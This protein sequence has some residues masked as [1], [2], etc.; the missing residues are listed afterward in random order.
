MVRKEK[1]R[2]DR[3]ET[4]KKR[5]GEGKT[6]HY[7]NYNKRFVIERVTNRRIPDIYFWGVGG[8]NIRAMCSI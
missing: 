8:G 4:T 2:S 7:Y 1:E 3:Q 6:C 5:G